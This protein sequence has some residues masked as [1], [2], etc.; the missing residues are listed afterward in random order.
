MLSKQQTEED[1]RQ[2]VQPFG[3][4]EECTVLRGTDGGSKGANNDFVVV[5]IVVKLNNGQICAFPPKIITKQY[6]IV[7]DSKLPTVFPAK[8]KSLKFT[9]FLH[10]I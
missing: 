2:L 9:N 10:C 8:K 5:F 4:I 6:Y 7:V 3:N 1:V